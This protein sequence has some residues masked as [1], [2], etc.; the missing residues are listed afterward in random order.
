MYL[1]AVPTED[2]DDEDEESALVV[3][4][5]ALQ[6]FVE[7]EE[8]EIRWR[9]IT[10]VAICCCLGIGIVGGLMAVLSRVASESEGGGD[11]AGPPVFLAVF[12]YG[13]TS[14]GSISP[15]STAVAWLISR[16]LLKGVESLKTVANGSAAYRGIF[17]PDPPPVAFP[18]VPDN[19]TLTIWRPEPGLQAKPAGL[20]VLAHGRVAEVLS[21][22]HGLGV[23]S[24][25]ALDSAATPEAD[26]FLRIRTLLEAR[27]VKAKLVV[28]AHPHHL[29]YLAV[30]AKSAGLQLQVLD[31][32]LFN[33]VPWSDF[34]CGPLGY[35]LSTSPV[36]MLDREVERLTTLTSSLQD[37]DAP[38]EWADI[39]PVVA[40]ATSSLQYHHCVAAAATAGG[41][42]Q[43]LSPLAADTCRA[44]VDLAAT[45]YG[46]ATG[47]VGGAG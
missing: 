41:Q 12:S 19:R 40:A 8:A 20:Q 46:A 29:A 30:L 37:S 34:G 17:V 27:E 1:Q 32:S 42:R 21:Q 5:G 15:T 33:M 31:P 3:G 13:N 39:S 26:A 45:G 22:E 10:A 28:A 38:E 24:I 23:E 44:K 18:F 35:G 36:A 11:E 43:L 9:L 16:I 25:H 14:S 7:E 2:P 4:T 6:A 47:P